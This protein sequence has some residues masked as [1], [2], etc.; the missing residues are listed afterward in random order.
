M[1]SCT[2]TCICTCSLHMAVIEDTCGRRSTMSEHI[3]SPP[4]PRSPH[5]AA[6]APRAPPLAPRSYIDRP[7]S[8]DGVTDCG[9][10]TTSVDSFDSFNAD[11]RVHGRCT[12]FAPCEMEL[13][14]PSTCTL[15]GC[16]C[17]ATTTGF[18][19]VL[20]PPKKGISPGVDV[21]SHSRFDIAQDLNI[22]RD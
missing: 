12:A 3:T 20:P 8:A 19:P 2:C 4:I 21:H 13:G 15:E 18:Y 1:V 16:M 5:T 11:V 7:H 9:L 17:W 10:V 22:A 6:R 14:I